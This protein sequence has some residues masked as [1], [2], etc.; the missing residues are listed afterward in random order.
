MP[1]MQEHFPAMA[2]NGP[3]S[4]GDQTQFD[5]RS[6]PDACRQPSSDT[7][8][9]KI[10]KMFTIGY[11]TK[12]VDVYIA[13]LL[14]HG[15][16]V[17]AD[18][19]SVPYSKRFHEYHRES[20][21]L[22]LQQAG[23]R[24]VYLGEELGPRSKDPQHYDETD[25][26]QFDR[27]MEAPLYR[28]GEQRLFTGIGKG[29]SIALTCACK[30]PAICHRSLLIGWTLLHRHGHE[31]QHILHEGVLETQAELEQRLLQETGTMVDMLAGAAEARRLA[32]KKQCLARAYRKSE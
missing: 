5:L 26:V 22:H 9:P 6:A 19:R 25:Q 17:V 3:A 2:L 21:I 20:L 15:V 8:I 32:W 29:Y 23:I 30:D 1:E 24:Y 27:L 10:P 7:L 18:V 31:L 13:Q 14:E 4:S 28:A 11:A 16:N 12:P